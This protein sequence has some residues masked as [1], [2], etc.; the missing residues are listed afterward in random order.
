M[1]LRRADLA[2]AHLRIPQ[3]ELEIEQSVRR[4]PPIKQPALIVEGRVAAGEGQASAK[5]HDD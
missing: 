4:L 2:A 1:D 5:H 3:L